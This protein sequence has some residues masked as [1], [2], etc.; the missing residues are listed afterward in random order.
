MRKKKKIKVKTAEDATGNVVTETPPVPNETPRRPDGAGSEPA[1]DSPADLEGQAEDLR[2]QL[3]EARDKLLRAK[4]EQ[5]N[6]QKRVAQELVAVRRYANADLIKS[7]L[8]TLDD[9]QRSLEH[10]ADTDTD[11]ATVRK[12]VQ[13]IYDNLIKVLRDHRLE[14]IDPADEP[15]DPR[16]HEAMLQQP[17]DDREPGTVIQVVQRGYRLEDRVLRPAKVIIA[18]A[19]ECASD[20]ES[21]EAADENT[22]APPAQGR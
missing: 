7:L 20:G 9:F 2:R 11:T 12:G 15:F 13:L 4:A 3:D 6:M 5:Q 14:V 21:G 16:Y 10:G 18:A 8:G 19:P 17:A 1:A 22:A